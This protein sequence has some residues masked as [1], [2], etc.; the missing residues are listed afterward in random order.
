MAVANY[1]GVLKSETLTTN[2]VIAESY[3]PGVGNLM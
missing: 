2:T 3:T 1:S